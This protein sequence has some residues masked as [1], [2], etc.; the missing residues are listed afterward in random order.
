MSDLAA[1]IQDEID[2]IE[3]EMGDQK[4]LIRRAPDNQPV[5]AAAE[6][7]LKALHTRLARLKGNLRNERARD[8]KAGEQ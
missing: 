8:Q 4:H 2:K 6:A 5:V 7:Q 3:R 1:Q